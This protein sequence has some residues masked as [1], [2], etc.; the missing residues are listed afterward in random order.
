MQK[1]SNRKIGAKIQ[2]RTWFT[3]FILILMHAILAGPSSDCHILLIKF[4]NS[5]LPYRSARTLKAMRVYSTEKLRPRWTQITCFT[6]MP[7]LQF[8]YFM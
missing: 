2:D 1:H 5:V 4:C 8:V 7:V 3:V 6:S